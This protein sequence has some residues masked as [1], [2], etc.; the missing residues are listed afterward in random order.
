MCDTDSIIYVYDPSPGMYNV[1]QGKKLGEWKEEKESI[2]GIVTFVGWGPK[3]YGLKM[4]DGSTKVKAKGLSLN[5]A[6]Q[7]LFNFNVMEAEMLKFL[8]GE[9]SPPVYVP[10][11]T[12]EWSPT[13]DMQTVYNLKEAR[14][15][16]DDLK[17]EL[18][19]NYLYPFGHE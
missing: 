13:L 14:I 16:R 15:N 19:G 18:R 11:F 17:G 8:R 4:K 7:E 6:T 1:T 5:Y 3:T 2:K 12:F 10:Q 9:E